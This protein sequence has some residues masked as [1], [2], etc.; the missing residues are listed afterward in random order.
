MGPFGLPWLTFGAL[1]VVV[2][3]IAIISIAWAVW[4]SGSGGGG[5]E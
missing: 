5:D 1:L 3:S 4:F 2:A